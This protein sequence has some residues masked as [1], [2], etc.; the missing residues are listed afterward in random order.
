MNRSS[1]R[2]PSFAMLNSFSGCGTLIKSRMYIMIDFEENHLKISNENNIYMYSSYPDGST[3]ER[4]N[5]RAVFQACT[6]KR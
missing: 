6:I 1:D 5:E 3:Q 2:Q 4:Q